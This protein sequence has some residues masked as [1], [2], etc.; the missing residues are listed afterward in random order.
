V[1][2][3]FLRQYRRFNEARTF[4]RA[5]G[6]K[7]VTEWEKYCKSGKKPDDIPAIPD[8][9]YANDGWAGWG[10]WLGTGRIADQLRE[11][12]PF[13]EARAFVHSLG[14]KSEAEWKEYCRSG[15]KPKD[16]PYKPQRTYANDGW[17][18]WGDWLG[19]GRIADQLREYR[20]F[21]EARAFVHGLGLKSVREWGDYCKSGKK[22]ADIPAQPSNTYADAGWLGWGDWLGTG[23]IATYV[24]QYRPFN[25]ARAFVQGLGLKSHTE[26][27]EYCKSG[28]KPADIPANPNRTYADAGWLG[29]GDWLGTGRIADRLRQYRSFKDARAFV[30]GLGL[31]SQSDWR[32]YRASGKKPADI[33]SHPDEVYAE[34][35]WAGMGDWLGTDNR[36]GGW[37]PFKES[38]TFA[39][40]LKLKSRADWSA[41]YKSGKRP[42]DIPI[43]P[44]AVYATDGWL[45][46][47]DWL[48]Y[49]HHESSQMVPGVTEAPTTC[50]KYT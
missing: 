18:G 10:D 47:G 23:T 32:E 37:R 6:L 1:V 49:T 26:W 42:P 27:R 39:R 28:K 12:R 45:G 17:A 19:T 46:W 38:R 50:G 7:S 43:A 16:I 14:L 15:K 9:T 31:K 21:N 11:Y 20:P 5:L 40:G 41:Y 8:R 29:W 3:T 33:P 44:N 30:H 4:V 48:G 36:R 25:E 2:A 22:P 24:F 35:G 13:N 34:A